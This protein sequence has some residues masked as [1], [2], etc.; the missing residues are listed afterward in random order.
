M[1]IFDR[2]QELSRT[3]AQAITKTDRIVLIEGYCLLLDLAP[4]AQLAKPFD[5]TV[6]L[7]VPEETLRQHLIQRWRDHGF[8]DVNTWPKPNAMICPTRAWLYN[9]AGTRILHLATG[10]GAQ[11][12]S[13]KN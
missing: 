10:E 3:S 11:D 5:L 7:N 4:W 6:Y 2:T 12:E 9:T 1:P 13:S 8:E